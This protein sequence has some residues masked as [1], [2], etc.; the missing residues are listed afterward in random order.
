MK[1]T[2]TTCLLALLPLCGFSQN[3][4]NERKTIWPTSKVGTIDI[5]PEKVVDLS[6]YGVDVTA[7]VAIDEILSEAISKLGSSGGVIYMPKGNYLINKTINL[8]S[9]T[10]LIGDGSNRT[11]LRLNLSGTGHGIE[12]RGIISSTWLKINEEAFKGDKE[13]VIS[14]HNYKVG[15]LL[16]IRIKAEAC[17]TSSWAKGS[18]GQ[19]VE[20]LQV[21]G[22]TILLKDPLR[23]DLPLSEDAEVSK[24]TP[25][26][27]CGVLNMSIAREDQTIGQTDNIHFEYTKNALVYGVNSIKCNFSHVSNVC[28][29]ETFVYGSYF[30]E[31]FD[32][33]SGGKAYGV[34]LAF[35]S[36]QCVVE[37]NIFSKL[38]HSVLFQAGSNGN[39]VGYNYSKDPFWTDVLLPS[40][41]AGDIVM[42]GNYPFMNLIEG[43]I[44][45]NLVI[46]NSHG[47][48][49]P[50]NTFMR[51]RMENA[52]L[53]MNNQPASDEQIYIGNEI[54]GTGTSSNGFISFPK[55]LYI[56]E[57]QDHIEF[58]NNV[59]GKMYPKAEKIDDISYYYSSKP[60]WIE[61]NLW[62]AIGYPRLLNEGSIPSYARSTS[63]IKTVSYPFKNPH[64]S[65]AINLIGSVE[66]MENKL[67]WEY[68]GTQACPEFMVFRINPN[69]EFVQLTTLNCGST[70]FLSFTDRHFPREHTNEVNSYFILVQQTNGEWIASDT[71]KLKV[72]NSLSSESSKNLFTTLGEP[73]SIIL[74]DINGR[75]IAEAAT[76]KTLRREVATGIYVASSTYANGMVTQKKVFLDA[77]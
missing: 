52:G 4:Q 43:N 60:M 48:N 59:N 18:V 38:R 49:G 11:T 74:R 35:T 65:T 26:E 28:A 58:A 24:I 37:N 14:N 34:V 2:A 13:V 45:Q 71:L 72:Q 12:A 22:N 15:D 32:Y 6:A 39:V 17:I 33:G 19:I 64:I 50:N 46:D 55:G 51:N 69:K 76:F 3:I 67:K 61:S 36:S 66:N 63:S 25:I 27:N 29:Y 68:S 57:G 30:T 5:S 40:D 9:N 54:T 62:P 73:E 7:Q 16:R 21:D 56:L 41:F 31:G 75:V 20:V 53:F 1:I 47:K 77:N 10:Y 70:D 44:I 42:H 23:L 8:P